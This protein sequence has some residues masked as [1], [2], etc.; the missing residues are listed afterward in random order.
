MCIVVAFL[1]QRGNITDVSKPA[2]GKEV[3]VRDSW[4]I[5]S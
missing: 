2:N 1:M 4:F 3:V 5:L